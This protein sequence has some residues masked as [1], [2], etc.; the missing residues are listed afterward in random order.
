MVNET[1]DNK[2]YLKKYKQLKNYD[3]IISFGASDTQNILKIC[4]IINYEKFKRFNFKIL[5]GKYYKYEKSL[6]Q[7]VL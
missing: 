7:T 2:N 3:I 6:K 4:D 1:Y 5:I